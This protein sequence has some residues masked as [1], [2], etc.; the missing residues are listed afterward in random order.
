MRRGDLDK[1]KVPRG[2]EQTDDGIDPGIEVDQQWGR[3]RHSPQNVPLDRPFG[4]ELK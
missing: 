2:I 1:I 4:P 3:H